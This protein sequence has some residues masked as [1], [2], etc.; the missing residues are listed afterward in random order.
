M[1]YISAITM[2]ILAFITYL[3]LN[4]TK[5]IRKMY[6]KTFDYEHSP[7]VFLRDVN[8]KLQLDDQKRS[9]VYLTT[10]KFKN[11]GKSSALNFEY[12]YSFV[13]GNLK[14]EEKFAP[15]AY[16]HPEQGIRIEVTFLGVPLKDDDSY[17][18]AKKLINEGK[19]IV[20]AAPQLPSVFLNVTLKYRT[21]DNNKI[22]HKYALEHI[23]NKNIWVHR[24]EKIENI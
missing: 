11:T 10:L 2:I 24:K 1:E 14:K 22:E 16:L 15:L 20:I 9:L 6:E 7:K 13:S 5:K 17:N 4:E 19:S 8:S 23:P 21:Q 18:I 12:K 3:Y